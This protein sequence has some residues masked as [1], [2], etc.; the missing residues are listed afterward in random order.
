M[1]DEIKKSYPHRKTKEVF[2]FDDGLAKQQGPFLTVARPILAA[3]MLLKSPHN[4]DGEEGGGGGPDPD[5]VR[6][7]LEDALVMLGNANA[8]SNV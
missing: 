6:E 7:V 1:K 5:T 3:L 4:E 8:R 2:T